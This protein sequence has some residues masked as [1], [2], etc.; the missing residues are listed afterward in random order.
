[1]VGEVARCHGF[2]EGPQPLRRCL[3]GGVSIGSETLQLSRR[4]LDACVFSTRNLSIYLSIHLRCAFLM[5]SGGH[6]ITPCFHKCIACATEQETTRATNSS[7][8]P[9][10]SAIA[11]PSRHLNPAGWPSESDRTFA[12]LQRPPWL[13]DSRTGGVGVCP[14]KKIDRASEGPYAGLPLLYLS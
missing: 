14:G 6:H 9:Q 8:P 4:S 10:P 3:F 12:G 1:M 7:S 5:M 13:F 11:R 2:G